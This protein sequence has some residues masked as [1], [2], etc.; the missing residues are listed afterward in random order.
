MRVSLIDA[1]SG[2]IYGQVWQLGSGT[3]RPLDM[4]VPAGTYRWR[5]VPITGSAT[6]SG[7]A[8]VTGKGGK[9]VKPLYPLSSEEI[10]DAMA[11][12]H[13]AVERGIG[14]LVTATSALRSAVRA[15]DL[16]TAR[17][18]WLPAHLAYERLGAAYGTFADLD[19]TINGRPDGLP[20]GVHDKGFTGFLRVEYGLW[21][22]ESAASL[23]PVVDALDTAVHQLARKFPGQQVVPSDIPLRAHEILENTLQFE[24]TGDTDQGSH[25]NL[26]TAQANT[27]GA[28][29]V[30]HVLAQQLSQR[31][32]QLA[33]KASKGLTTLDTQLGEYRRNG[34]WTPLSMLSR[35]ER[36]HLNASVGSVVETLALI[37]DILQMPPSTAPT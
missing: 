13:T 23:R 32:P 14:T 11:E 16:S 29:M 22:G 34:R 7:T 15:G 33:S 26:A 3:T 35:S 2:G 6:V 27:E 28:M 30:V 19:G 12:Y 31:D 21:H 5:C 9:G 37:P 18:R 10:N 17:E 36:E 20:K 8:K 1:N 4:V 24:L 25:T